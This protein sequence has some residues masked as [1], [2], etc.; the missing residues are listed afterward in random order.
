MSSLI[1]I[2]SQS[3]RYLVAFLLV[4][5]SLFFVQVAQASTVTEVK[6]E[7]GRSVTTLTFSFSDGKPRYRYYSLKALIV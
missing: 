6:A 2:V 3:Q 1:T 5:F 4:V 7:N